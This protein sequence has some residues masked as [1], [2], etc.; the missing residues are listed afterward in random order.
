MLQESPSD[1]EVAAC[2]QT[3][4]EVESGTSLV[5][6]ALK[7]KVSNFREDVPVKDRYL[8]FQEKESA[9]IQVEA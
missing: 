1:L 8:K 7:E 3:T 9:A 5:Q 2:R 4:W 6:E